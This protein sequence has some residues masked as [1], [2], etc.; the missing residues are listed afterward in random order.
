V[1]QQIGMPPII[2]QHMQPSPI[3][4]DMQSQQHCTMPAILASPLMQVIATPMSIISQAVAAIIMLHVQQDM[5]FIIIIQQR[6]LPAII[7]HML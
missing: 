2:M 1:P 4:Q 3:M 6:G 7:W 5:P